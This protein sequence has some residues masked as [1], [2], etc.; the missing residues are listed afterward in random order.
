MVVDGGAENEKS[1]D[2]CLK[3][4]NIRKITVTPYHAAA[5]AIIERGYRPIADALSKLPSSSDE[6]KEMWINHLPA[7]HWANR[8]TF[9][10]TTGYSPFRHMI[11]QDAVLPF[12][13][14]N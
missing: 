7:L 3:H 10:C 5:N 2:H 4:Y 13:L 9:R 6:P 11:G 12:E 14:E 8:I 1:T